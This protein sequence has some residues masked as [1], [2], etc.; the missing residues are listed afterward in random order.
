MPEIAHTVYQLNYS[1]NPTEVVDWLRDYGY[2]AVVP[3]LYRGLGGVLYSRPNEPVQLA[4]IGDHLHYSSETG[5][6]TNCVQPE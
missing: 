2:R 5:E 3:A 4:V 6:V 1:D